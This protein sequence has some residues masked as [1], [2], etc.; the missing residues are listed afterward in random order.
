MIEPD[1]ANDCINIDAPLPAGIVAQARSIRFDTLPPASRIDYTKC[2]NGYKQWCRENEIE[3]F[4][5]EDA[6]LVFLQYCHTEKQHQPS[7]LTSNL[8]KI[9]SCFKAF[10]HIDI[11]DYNGVNYFLKNLRRDHVPK[12]AR[13]LAEEEICQFCREAPE[14]EYLPHKVVFAIGIS[15][16]MRITA[17]SKL[18]R[19]NVVVEGS[20]IVVT[21]PMNDNKNL[22][23][24]KETI[25]KYPYE[26][27]KFLKLP[28]AEEYTSHCMRR[29]SATIYADSGAS[30]ADVQRHGHWKNP[31]CASRYVG[32]SKYLK[33]NKAHQITNFIMS[34]SVSN[35]SKV[36]P[37]TSVQ[38]VQPND[39]ISVKRELPK[40]T[41]IV[42]PTID[43]ALTVQHN[44]GFVTARKKI[45]I[46]P[47]T[48]T[49]STNNMQERNHRVRSSSSVP[50]PLP[51]MQ[52]KPLI[53]T[54]TVTSKTNKQINETSSSILNGVTLQHNQK[55]MLPFPSGLQDYDDNQS[56]FSES[57]LPSPDYTPPFGEEF[58]HESDYPG[59]TVVKSI[60]EVFSSFIAPNAHN[61]PNHELVYKDQ[62]E[63][64]EQDVSDIQNQVQELHGCKHLY[65]GQSHKLI[66]Q[67]DVLGD[68]IIRQ[69]IDSANSDSIVDNHMSTILHNNVQSDFFNDSEQL[70]GV[71]C[72]STFYDQQDLSKAIVQ[73][74]HDPNNNHKISKQRI[75]SCD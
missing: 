28:Y 36:Q 63:F 17:I 35:T 13:I 52:Q 15:G 43:S 1:I 68:D 50:V 65:Q 41:S 74:Q 62:V 8:S 38:P 30:T 73:Q 24:G 56:G 26:V 23:T 42:T 22:V 53:V 67:N 27:A 54:P 19:T 21:S 75:T 31:S 45:S 66:H 7:T 12:Q 44:N 70:F 14:P 48:T 72:D 16:C 40:I 59:G 25:A 37:L 57:P 10:H 4:V 51:I 47:S 61:P 58:S 5:H 49:S 55:Q 46:A 34:N 32:D 9:K 39:A 29:S 18:L 11:S 3:N 33:T 2:Y 64:M 20:K 6:L 60:S 69:H 71:E